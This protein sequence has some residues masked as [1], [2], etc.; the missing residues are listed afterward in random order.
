MTSIHQINTK[1][2][3]QFEDIQ[4]LIKKQEKLLEE[5]NKNID[6]KDTY[7]IDLKHTVKKLIE[8][9]FSI[10]EICE[11]TS[12]SPERYEDIVTESK[13]YQM[14]NKYLNDDER[15]EYDR[16]LREIRQSK[17]IYD[18]INPS[19]EEERIKL[20]HKVL[21]R[22]LKEY[23]DLRKSNN[24]DKY[25]ELILNYIDRRGKNDE[26]KRAYYCLVRRFGNEI[27]K[28]REDLLIKISE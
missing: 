3:R 8:Y 10:D 16:L 13:Y 28:M 9:G 15:K 12:I 18:L 2:K 26:A 22:Y 23:D 21:L 25:E 1:L 24:S 17:D 20:I 6:K 4:D 5:M 14:P 7:I 11:I 27:N 19:K